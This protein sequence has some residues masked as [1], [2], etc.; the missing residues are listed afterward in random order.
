MEEGFLWRTLTL[1]M[2]TAIVL[3]PVG[4]SEHVKKVRRKRA[5]F[6]TKVDA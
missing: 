4:G 3:V 2:A 1:V 5:V 6:D